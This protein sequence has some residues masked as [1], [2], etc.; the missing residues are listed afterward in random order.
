MKAGFRQI[1]A[2]V[3][4]WA[5]LLVGWLLYFVFVTG[6][7]GYFNPEIDHWMRPEEPS[8]AMLPT[9]DVVVSQAMAHLH[10]RGAGAANWTIA[11]PGYRGQ[12]LT[13]IRWR[14]GA[15]GKDGRESI[16][17]ATGQTFVRVVR[18]TGGGRALY[19]MHYELRYMPDI[20]GI[21]AVGVAAMAMLLAIVTGVITH[22]KIFRDFFTFRPGKRQRSWL[23]AHNLLSVAAL[24]FCLM[25]TYSGLVFFDYQYVFAAPRIV[26]GAG[27]EDRFYAERDPRERDDDGGG[28][29]PAASMAPTDTM[30][31]IAQRHWGAGQ[32]GRISIEHPERAG[33]RV[34][35][36]RHPSTILRSGGD[37]L[38]FDGV[39]GRTLGLSAARTAVIGTFRAGLLGLHEGLFASGVLRWLYF[40]SGCAGTAMVAT[41]LILWTSKRR[42]KADRLGIEPPTG[43]RVAE[44]LNAGVIAG[45]PVG[46]AAYFWANRLLPIGMANRADWEIHSLFLTWAAMLLWAGIVSPQRAW[47]R[48]LWTGAVAFGLLPV[49]N[50]VTTGRHIA[51]ALAKG[52]GLFVG[53]DLTML[54]AATLSGSIA[55]RMRHWDDRP[56]PQ[57]SARCRQVAA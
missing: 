14:G 19:V 41:G 55:I 27:N 3:H 16:D 53:F 22:K 50:A 34:T 24:P 42:E 48:L 39:S 4:G 8:A 45:L 46:I 47:T 25:I 56:A 32:V 51:L 54:V 44:P 28:T 10:R 30:L 31:A 52:D 40:L 6:T 2:Q 38:I 9:P 35:L 43:V 37:A 21:W 5:G 17:P 7:I 29:G 26:Y 20:W 23:D 12:G 1:M 49:I 15:D 18:D 57:R 11:L 33:A 13:D 36:H